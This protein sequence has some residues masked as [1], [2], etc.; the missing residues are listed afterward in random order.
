[1]LITTYQKEFLAFLEKHPPPANPRNL[2][3]PTAYILS[4][5]GKRIRPILALMAADAV[6]SDF[7]KA[8]PAAMTVEV[9]HNFSLVHDDIMDEAPLRRGKPT[10]HSKWDVNTGILSGDVMLVMA[11]EWLNEYPSTLFKNLTEL[12][13][14]TAKPVSYTHLTLPTTERV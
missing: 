3:D 5:G 13:S 11:Y 7:K 9:F 10:V 12:F 6:G 8:L 14:K 1:M 4:L 2:F